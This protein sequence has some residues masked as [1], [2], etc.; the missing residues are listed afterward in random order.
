MMRSKNQTLMFSNTLA[1]HWQHEF[2][3]V[4]NSD[5]RIRQITSLCLWWFTTL[6]DCVCKWKEPTQQPN[7]AQ[8]HHCCTAPYNNVL[9][10]G[11]DVQ[12]LPLRPCE[13][14]PLLSNH[15]RVWWGRQMQTLPLLSLLEILCLYYSFWVILCLRAQSKINYYLIFRV[16]SLNAGEELSLLVM[17]TFCLTSLPPYS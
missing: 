12:W 14:L 7:S 11:G 9:G 2:L 10:G 16:P 3:S 4:V 15:V 8:H 6:K 17:L 5:H 1:L 13:T